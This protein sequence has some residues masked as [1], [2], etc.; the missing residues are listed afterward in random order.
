VKRLQNEK[1]A[2]TKVEIHEIIKDSN[3][4]EGKEKADYKK[5]RRS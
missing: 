2:S 4:S 3:T 1:Y 5:I